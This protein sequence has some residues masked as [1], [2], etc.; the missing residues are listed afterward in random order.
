MLD[1]LIPNGASLT[2]VCTD[3]SMTDTAFR[4]VGMDYKGNEIE[5]ASGPTAKDALL[6]YDRRA[7]A[8]DWWREQLEQGDQEYQEDHAWE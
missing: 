1:Q 3:D 7:H 2:R 8:E 5:L 6:A 4:L